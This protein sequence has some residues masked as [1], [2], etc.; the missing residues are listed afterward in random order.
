MVSEGDKV[1]LEGEKYVGIYK[2]KKGNSVQDGVS[3]TSLEGSSS[4]GRASRKNATGRE[5]SQ[6][7]AG[8]R[9]DAFGQS[10]RWPKA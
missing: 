5:L 1:I 9:K 3:M 10:P 7:V 8:K 2:M 4:R 6:S